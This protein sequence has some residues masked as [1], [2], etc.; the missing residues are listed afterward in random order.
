MGIDPAGKEDS[1]L[2]VTSEIPVVR[3]VRP[4]T[5]RRQRISKPQQFSAVCRESRD[6]S[7]NDHKK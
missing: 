6:E 7:E 2:R 1:P 4:P 5:Q 3:A